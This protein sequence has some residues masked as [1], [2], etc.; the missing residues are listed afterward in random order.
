MNISVILPAIGSA[1]KLERLRSVITAAASFAQVKEIILVWQGE[2]TSSFLCKL[3]ETVRVLICDIKALSYA[4]NRGAEHATNEWL[5]FLDD[6]TIPLDN[7][8]ET[9]QKYILSQNYDFVFSNIVTAGPKRSR[10]S[11]SI[12]RS[13]VIDRNSAPNNAWEPGLLIRR[14]EFLSLKF[15]ED[16]GIGCIHSA[17][18]GV[19]LAMRLLGKGLKGIRASD[20]W[21]DHPAIPFDASFGNKLA[22]YSLG[23]G[24]VLIYHRLFYRY[25]VSITR[26]LIRFI[27]AMATLNVFE[28][29]LYSIRILAL[30]L[31][32]MLLPQSPAPLEARSVHELVKGDRTDVGFV[33]IGSPRSSPHELPT[34]K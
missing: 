6:D 9:A 33:R 17:S 34:P 28:I 13:V 10:A 30:A 16:L 7:Y 20:L 22:L 27:V 2:N 23:N 32:P 4:R 8:I 18:E 1:Q 15:R 31:G 21:L 5:W 14:A 29:R 24:Y 12:E 25:F 26:A 11:E 3:P 19:D